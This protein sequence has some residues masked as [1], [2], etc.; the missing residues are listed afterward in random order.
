MFYLL[1]ITPSVWSVV[2]IKGL[3]TNVSKTNNAALVLKELG[4]LNWEGKSGFNRFFL[5]YGYNLSYYKCD[6]GP[7]ITVPETNYIKY[8]GRFN[9]PL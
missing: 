4:S 2:P 9:L 6:S 1:A 3:T 8:I 5:T 7:T